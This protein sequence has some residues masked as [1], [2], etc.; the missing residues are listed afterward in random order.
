MEA[1]LV[2]EDGRVFE[3][4]SFGAQGE[5]TGEVVF[6]TGMT[7]YQEVLTDP[8]Y[9]G[10]I[11]TMT[12]A[13]IGNTGVNEIDPE[14]ERP[15]VAG[16]LV[17]SYTDDYSSWRARTALAH[18]L[19]EHE[20][21]ALAD[22]DTRALTRHI[23]EKGALRAAISTETDDTEYL[24]NLAR[25]ASPMEGLDL[26]SGVGTRQPYTWSQGSGEWAGIASPPP[27][28][29][30]VAYDFGLKRNIL[31]KLVDHGAHVTVV[32]V[33]TTA[34]DVLALKP[35]GVFLSNGPGDPATLDYAVK[36]IETLLG[37]TPMFGICLGHQ[38][39]GLA[40]GGS[41]FKLPYGHHGCNHP[42][43]D[44]SSGHVQITS[45][46]HGFS[47][48]AE[49]LPDDIEVTH[50][51]LNDGTVEGLRHTRYPAFS[52]QYHPEA[53]P[54]PHDA[55]PLFTEFVRLM[56]QERER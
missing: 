7:G 31:R 18:Y 38:L 41:T 47:V 34:E 44:L 42:V 15:Y 54:G 39:M 35:D 51:N 4:R 25:T 29:H 43:K 37:R 49:S 22:I 20:I 45:Q 40:V 3:G 12:A 1:L 48:A 11:V 8:S 10:Q 53:A 6:A 28:L 16:F 56:E 14:A 2:L 26:A 13:H 50:R 24:L 36:H 17:R 33:T 9:A 5:T 21:V 46:N 55:D 19:R 27:R 52:V 30:V 32:P 23:R